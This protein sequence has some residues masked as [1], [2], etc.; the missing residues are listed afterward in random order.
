MSH[1]DRSAERGL[2]GVEEGE[3]KKA[4]NELPKVIFYRW[5]W[6]LVSVGCGIVNKYNLISCGPARPGAYHS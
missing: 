1:H 5:I 3:G 4:E 2:N 6:R